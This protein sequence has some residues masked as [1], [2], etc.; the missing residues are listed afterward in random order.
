[1]IEIIEINTIDKTIIGMKNK[2]IINLSHTNLTLLNNLN[3]HIILDIAKE[4]IVIVKQNHSINQHHTTQL[5]HYLILPVSK[6]KTHTDF[7]HY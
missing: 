1:M 7:I 4:T 5:I 3:N 6:V 2:T